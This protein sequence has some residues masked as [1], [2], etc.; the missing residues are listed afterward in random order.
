MDN[1]SEQLKGTHCIKGY[2]VFI[3]WS[4]NPELVTE[5]TVA[6]DGLVFNQER[7]DGVVDRIKNSLGRD[8][9]VIVA[10]FVPK[11]KT[12]TAQSDLKRQRGVV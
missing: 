5:Y 12:T 2:R 7:I 11:K 3:N 1:E 8:E 9:Q 10:I 4:P 6:Y